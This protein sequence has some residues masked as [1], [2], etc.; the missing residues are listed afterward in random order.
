MG[1]VDTPA[2]QTAHKDRWRQ[3][4]STTSLGRARQTTHDGSS[5][6]SWAA[7]GDGGAATGGGGGPAGALGLGGTT[8][9]P[10]R[11]AG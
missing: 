6:P 5:S 4:K 3:G 8:A 10:E 9:R 2:A 1:H 7:G 11:D